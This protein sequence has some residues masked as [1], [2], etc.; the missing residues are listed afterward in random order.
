MHR[1]H[2][3]LFLTNC[4]LLQISVFANFF[5]YLYEGLFVVTIVKGILHLLNFESI[6]PV[7]VF[8]LCPPHL[9]MSFFDK[10]LEFN[11]VG[12]TE[13]VAWQEELSVLLKTKGLSV[14]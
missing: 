3:P 13:F 5:A 14:L 9:L 8:I 1:V 6:K 2:L 4:P 7:P 12:N 11:S 10:G